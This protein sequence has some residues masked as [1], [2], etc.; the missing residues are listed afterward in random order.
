M[1]RIGRFLP[2][3]LAGALT[4]VALLPSPGAAQQFDHPRAEWLGT[5]HHRLHPRAFARP[6]WIEHRAWRMD[7]RGWR[8]EHRGWRME[9]RGWQ[10]EHRR[11]MMQRRWRHAPRARHL[12]YRFD[13]YI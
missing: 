10:M 13:G 8:M 3:I 12:R 5:W 2:W 6:Y 9:R 1:I 4:G 11:W 7:H